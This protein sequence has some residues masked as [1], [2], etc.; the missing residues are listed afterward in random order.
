MQEK[1]Q[2]NDDRDKHLMITFEHL[3]PSVPEISNTSNFPVAQ[4]SSESH[5]LLSK[6]EEG[7]YLLWLTNTDEQAIPACRYIKG[8]LM[9][10]INIFLR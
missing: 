4:L 7:F 10:R 3:D 5:S 8:I 6:F 9:G 2:L 1:T